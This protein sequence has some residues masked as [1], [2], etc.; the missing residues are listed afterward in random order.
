MVNLSS[1]EVSEFVSEGNVVLD[2]W[3]SWCGPCQMLVPVF[4]DISQEIK[5][6]KFGKANVDD[7]SDAAIKYEVKGVPTL[8][9]FKEGKEVNRVVGFISKDALKAKIE[10]S[11]N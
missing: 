11:F 10:E 7:A 5:T 6:V 4:E 9:F 1:D 8:I 3:A 2:F